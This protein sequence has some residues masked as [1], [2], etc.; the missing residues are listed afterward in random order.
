MIYNLR[1]QYSMIVIEKYWNLKLQF[2]SNITN[3]VAQRVFEM[4]TVGKP[5]DCVYLASCNVHATPSHGTCDKCLA[6]WRLQHAF[7]LYYKI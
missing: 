6:V 5:C 1:K 7:H 4:S 3:Q 2:Y